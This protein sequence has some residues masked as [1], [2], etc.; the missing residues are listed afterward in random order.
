MVYEGESFYE[1]IRVF[2][3][4]PT[5]FADHIARLQASVALRGRQMVADISTLRNKIIELSG[6]EEREEINLKIVFNYAGER[7]NYLIYYIEPVYPGPDQ[8][9][10][11]VKGILFHAERKDPEVKVIDNLL[12]SEI[13]RKL[14]LEKGYE[15]L[16]V[17][18]T[19]C[20]TEGS[21]SNIFFISGNR[22]I[23]APDNFVLGGI[24]RKHLI[25]ICRENEIPVD[26][27]C[28]NVN[29]ITDQESIVM[30]GT[31]P[32]VLPFSSVGDNI[33]SVSH[34]LIAHLRNLYR[35]KAEE[36]MIQF[37]G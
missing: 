32:I 23:T 33:F 35:R 8:Y 6:A 12:R 36:S 31:S 9:L 13:S 21:R 28:V 10:N 3:G 11:G 5:F 20:I 27:R 18:R 1:V 19:G 15:A 7:C 16:L 4:L 22:L 26:F 24:T 2:G 34:P 37:T 25:G 14:I 29:E 30:T 17:N